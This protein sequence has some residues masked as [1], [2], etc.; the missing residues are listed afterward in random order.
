MPDL[1]FTIGT[2]S[3]QTGCSVPTI[4]YYEKNGLLPRPGRAFNG[5]RHYCEADLN[6][7]SFIKRCRDFGF[8]IEQVRELAGLFEDGDRACIE[9]RHVAQTRLDEVQAKL[10]ELRELEAS[11]ATFV[12][13]CDAACQGGPAKDCVILDGLSTANDAQVG[14]PCCPNQVETVPILLTRAE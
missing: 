12:C 9:V 13:S 3:A 2:M 5:H 11:L 10:A 1:Q 6:R 7:L 8:S 14:V 4:R